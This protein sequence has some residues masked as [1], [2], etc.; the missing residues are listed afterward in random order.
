M[1]SEIAQLYNTSTIKKDTYL[2]EYKIDIDVPIVHKI[3]PEDDPINDS[4][5]SFYQ[6]LEMFNVISNESNYIIRKELQ[7]LLIRD[8]YTNNFKL[9]TQLSK[10]K[11]PMLLT[12]NKLH[13]LYLLDYYNKIHNSKA[14]GLCRFVWENGKYV[15]VPFP[16]FDK[17]L[18][19]DYLVNTSL[20]KDPFDSIHYPSKYIDQT[21]ND[22]FTAITYKPNI[23]I[24]HSLI[25]QHIIVPEIEEKINKL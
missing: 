11:E 4:I 13:K 18:V 25:F 21:A 8:T 7:N 3:N 6:F 20:L 19:K 17:K 22:L 10:M 2:N 16:T 1:S 23:Q 9:E 15:Y 5:E 12:D 24:I 14:I